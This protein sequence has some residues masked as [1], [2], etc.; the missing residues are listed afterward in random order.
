MNYSAV[1]KALFLERP[2]RFIARCL[3]EGQEVLA[4]VPNTGRCREL[5]V[6]G[7]TVY[8]RDWRGEKT[9]RKT[10]FSLLTV[11]KGPLLINMDAQAPN[12][13]AWEGLSSGRI[14]LP[15]DSGEE[16]LSL[17]R[18]VAWGQSRFDLLAKTSQRDWYVEVK[19]V[20]LEDG[21]IAR[22]PD[23]PTERG[24]RHVQELCR[25]KESGCGAALLFIVQLKGSTHLE[26]NWQTHRAFG[27]A[28]R[29]AREAGVALLC[30]DCLVTPE[31]VQ[32]SEPLPIS[33]DESELI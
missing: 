30:Y 4:H 16:L 5:L 15:L 6:P 8:L 28:L 17:R 10:D 20:T 23:A 19:G 33:L 21:G 32:V 22:F 13:L 29:Q 9:S 12:R 3:L 14:R 2:N 27:E 11:E 1:K 18:E 26:P 25:V 31:Q 24:L 7:C